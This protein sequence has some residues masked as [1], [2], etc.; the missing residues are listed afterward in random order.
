VKRKPSLPPYRDNS[1]HLADELRCLDLLLR[2]AIRNQSLQNQA[3]PEVQAARAA[4]V[5]AAEVEWLLSPQQPRD[6]SEDSQHQAELARLRR[7]I[8]GR[9]ASSGHKGIFLPLAH[10]CDLFAL[11]TF[12]RDVIVICLAPELRR[13]YDRLYAFIQ[14]DITRKRP[15]VD[16]V[17]QLLC[18]G[19]AQ[20]WEARSILSE[21]ATLLRSGLLEKVADPY[22]PSGSSGLAEFLM[23]DARICEFLLGGHHIDARLAGGVRVLRPSAHEHPVPIDP[24]IVAGLWKL[25][26]HQ[27]APGNPQ[28]RKLVLHL[29]GPQG[30]GERDLALHLCRGLGCSLLQIDAELLLAKGS[31][32]EHLLRLIFRESLLHQ[33]AL[34]VERAEALLQETARPLLNALQVAVTEYGWLVFLS[35]AHPWIDPSGFPGCT[36]HSTA[37]P[38]PAVPIC[39]EVW[40]RTLKQET[41]EAASWAMQLATQFR[42]TPAQIEAAVE[43]VRTRKRME[44]EVTPMRLADLTAACRQH[45]KHKLRDLAVKIE[46]KAGWDDIVLP[47]DKIVHLREICS[48]FQ[49]RYRVFCDWGYGKK[50]SNGKGLSAIF[51]GPSGTGKTMAAEVLARELDLDLY[52]VDLS[53]V[54]SKYIGETEKNLRRI[55]DE[56]ETSNAILFFDEADALFGKRTKVA[57]AHDRYANVETSYLLQKM[58]EFEGVVILATNLSENMDDAFTRRVRFIVEFPFPDEANRLRIWQSHL[59]A[60]TPAAEVDLGT[61]AREFSLSG[62]NIRNIA[63]SAAFSAANEGSNIGLR[64]VLHGTRR[65]FEKLGRKWRDNGSRL[66]TGGN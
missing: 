27:L 31:Q 26:E 3:V 13:S 47:A 30:M 50:L 7:E 35:A 19:E 15:S 60:G 20:R 45:S 52:K 37:L 38:L 10:L 21:G 40:E 8:D 34:F 4:Y 48:H 18:D 36:F 39:A 41:P 58:E 5:S 28:R 61:L 16:L 24:E 64:H 59:A 2:R 55:F 11:S 63:L 46:P 1:E 44:R 66:A 49:Y 29:H 25:A 33:A 6:D 12:E 53:G 62:G 22:S 32:A 9:I 51:S 57:D 43:T 23:L 65:E 42:L 17:L 56:A 54:V 14:D